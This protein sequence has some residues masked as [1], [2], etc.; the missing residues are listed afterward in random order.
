M[1]W[2][3]C[4]EIAH[5]MGLAGMEIPV[6]DVER[7]ASMAGRGQHFINVAI[8]QLIGLACFGPR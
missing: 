2:P 8:T 4:K 1:G 3:V 7:A 5:G 6:L